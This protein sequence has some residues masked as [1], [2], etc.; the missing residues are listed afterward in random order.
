V[1]ELPQVEVFRRIPRSIGADALAPDIAA[2]VAKL[3]RAELV[4]LSFPMFWFSVPAILKGWIDR[5][6]LSGLCY[7]GR[8]FYD[9]RSSCRT[10]HPHRRASVS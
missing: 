9:R 3:A 6:L 8:R 1:P 4:M 2:E 10:D 5:V 7:G